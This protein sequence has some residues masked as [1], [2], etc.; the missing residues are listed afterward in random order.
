MYNGTQNWVNDLEK[1]IRINEAKVC[2][3]I[4]KKVLISS[5]LVVNEEDKKLSETNKGVSQIFD[6]IFNCIFKCDPKFYPFAMA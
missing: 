4:M 6:S 2:V 5:F 1:R 3:L